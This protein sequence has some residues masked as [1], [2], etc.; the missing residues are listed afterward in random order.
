LGH[1]LSEWCGHGPVLEEDIALSNI[2]LDCIG[3]AIN[4]LKLA[5]EVENKGRDE[6]HLAYFREAIEYKNLMLLEQPNTDF[7]YTMARQFFYDV[8]SLHLYEALQSSTL[9]PL[10]D[11]AAKSLKEVRYHYRHSQQWILRLGDGTAES[12]RR[13]Q[14]AIDELWMYTR[15]MFLPDAVDQRLL[16]PGIAVDLASIEVLWR[17]SVEAV[18]RQA[19]LAVPQK[20]AYF[21]SG[22]RQGRH[23][24]HLGLL[25]AQM[26]ILPRSYPD[27]KW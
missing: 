24:E 25:L 7:G 20:T 23:S 16:S 1:R 8:F 15:E 10:A 6:D 3:Q 5:G 12:H 13:I 14:Q 19:T 18:L 22:S 17:E 27:A 4:L 2:A 11:I 26:Q 21:S 9:R